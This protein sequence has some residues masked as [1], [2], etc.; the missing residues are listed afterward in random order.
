MD[1]KLI[2]NEPLALEYGSQVVSLY[3][4]VYSQPPYNE[5]NESISRFSQDWKNRVGSPGF[6]LVLS[7]DEDR[8]VGMAF[9]WKS[10]KGSY[11]RG[12]HG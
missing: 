2:E 3:G 8:I 6:R 4:E 1:I 11:W 12:H 9:G 10:K 7:F 5:S